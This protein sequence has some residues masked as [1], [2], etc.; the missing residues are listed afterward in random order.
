MDILDTDNVEA[1]PLA[2]ATLYFVANVN[3][4]ICGF[5]K[6]QQHSR[7]I[8]NCFYEHVTPSNADLWTFLLH[9][10]PPVQFLRR[11]F[12]IPVDNP[13]HDN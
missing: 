9:K 6:D 2:H 12:L 11:T 5:R 8:V 1:L 13:L 10:V 4:F 3:G 7:P